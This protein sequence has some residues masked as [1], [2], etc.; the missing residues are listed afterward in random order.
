MYMPRCVRKAFAC[1][2]N[3]WSTSSAFVSMLSNAA[4]EK[5]DLVKSMPMLAAHNHSCRIGFPWEGGFDS[6]GGY[7]LVLRSELGLVG[8]RR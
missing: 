7:I 6:A 2:E 4:T 3:A 5:K 8:L 1:C